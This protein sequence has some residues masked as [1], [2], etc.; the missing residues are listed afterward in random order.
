ML[1]E[2]LITAALVALACYV[3]YWLA[4]KFQPPAREILQVIA[5]LSG[6]IWLLVH[7]REI[8]HAIAGK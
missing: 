7:A 4:S 6:A 5:V 1:I 2:L 3:V 8:I